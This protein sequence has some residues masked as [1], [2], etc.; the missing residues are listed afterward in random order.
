MPYSASSGGFYQG[1]PRRFYD[2][3]TEGA[4]DLTLEAEWWLTDPK[5]PRRVQGSVVLGIKS[6]SGSVEETGTLFTPSGDVE[7]PVDEAFQLGDGGWGVL[8]RAQGTAML[9]GPWFG[10]GS[11]YYLVS[12]EDHYGVMQGG[13][14]RGVPDLYSA[15]LGGAYQIPA[16]KDLVVMLGG[17]INGAPVKDLIG[18]GD[19]YWRRPGYQIY[20]EPGIAWTHGKGT[21]ALSYPLRVYQNKQDSLLDES[22]NRRIGADFAAHLYKVSYSRRF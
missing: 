14:F 11:A 22:L 15:R 9:G 17:L 8:L 5:E 20:V 18:G 1:T 3:R 6:D 21:F 10:Y 19:L 4:G 12:L 13:N 16:Y 2:F 7:G